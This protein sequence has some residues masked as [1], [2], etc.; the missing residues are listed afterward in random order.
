MVGVPTRKAGW[1]RAGAELARR[2]RARRAARLRLDGPF[3]WPEPPFAGSPSR[4]RRL[5][6]GR[7]RVGQV[8]VD[9]PEGTI[10]DWAPGEPE[11]A[12]LHGMAWLDDLAALGGPQARRRAQAWVTEWI[13]RFGRGEGPGWTPELAGERLRRWVGQARFLLHP[14]GEGE[15]EFGRACA[16]QALFLERRWKSAPTGRA[17]IVAL[18][19]LLHGSLALP[20]RAAQAGRA[21]EALAR[22]AAATVDAGGA[23]ATRNPEEL[24]E[25]V[26]LLEG[27]N[28]ALAA[29]GRPGEAALSAAVA[30]AAPVLRALRH[31]DGSLGRFHGGGQGPEGR[32]D[33]VLAGAGRRP[34]AMR[35]ALVP[36]MGFLRLAAGRTTV[37]VDA[38][39]PP[40]GAASLAAHASTLAFEMASGRRPVIVSC[41][42]G[43]G[44]GARWRRAARATASHSTL[45]LDAASSSRLGERLAGD[46]RSPL[47]DGPKRV[48]VETAPP[49][50]D[51]L[52]ADVAHDGWRPLYGLTHA[53]MLR[54]SPDGRTLDGED[55]LT[56][57]TATDGVTFDRALD[58]SRGLGLPFALRF[59]LHPDVRA[60]VLA[61]G[62]V[63]LAL[64]NGED[65]VFT[66]EGEG[67]FTL[68]PS[69]WLERGRLQPRDS[70]QI[71]LSGRVLRPQ[72][73]LRWTLGKAY[74]T[75]EG[76][77][78]LDPGGTEEEP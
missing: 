25:I 55:M 48:I 35:G 60:E 58:G 52:K 27:A 39:A 10:W 41:G 6:E 47:V 29:A 12:L 20:G 44:F 72:T 26:G 61:D 40:Q 64:R 18:A 24:L 33:Q 57:L 67:E 3:Q 28:A 74:G 23:I 42:P 11:A 36:Q 59:H 45:S 49:G 5:L 2:L 50:D 15:A 54:L 65:W 69:V 13:D 62:S 53:R 75:P 34:L 77:R 8:L 51:G 56:T 31:A 30:R 37:L 63:G 16:A 1:R 43:E 14:K 7:L 66:A 73:R 68:E 17:R 76:L 78:D 22:E 32:L 19:G 46:G 70:L 4:G 21:A 71:V 38:A 9:E